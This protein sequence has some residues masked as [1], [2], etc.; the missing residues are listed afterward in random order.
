MLPF[1]SVAS[2]PNLRLGDEGPAEASEAQTA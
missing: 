2:A 1:R